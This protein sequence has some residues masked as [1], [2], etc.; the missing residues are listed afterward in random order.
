VSRNSQQLLLDAATRIC[1]A[2]VWLGMQDRTDEALRLLKDA[3]LI[4]ERVEMEIGRESAIEEE[5]RSVS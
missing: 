2:R 5:M 1:R 4:V 3:R